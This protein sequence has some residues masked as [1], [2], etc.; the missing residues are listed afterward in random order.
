[1]KFNKNKLSLI[2]INTTLITGVAISP[3]ALAQAPDLGEAEQYSIL[4]GST[5]TNTGGTTVTHDVGV[6]PGTAVTGFADADG[7]PGI[8]DPG[9]L[10]S[11]AGSAQAK[12][13][14]AVAYGHL[15]GLPV[16]TN[17]AAAMGSGMILTPGVYSFTG[18]ADIT[19]SL[20]LDANGDAEALFIFQIPAELNAASNSQVS[21]IDNAQVYNVYWQVGTSATLGTNAEFIGNILADQ[22]ITM[23]TGASLT[24]RALA[25]NA[26]TTLDTNAVATILAPTPP[27]SVPTLPQWSVIFLALALAVV[28]FLTMRKPQGKVTA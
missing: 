20:V 9:S 24:G 18:A 23:N 2:L 28:G 1:M 4:A 13:D 6:H 14:L 17:Q 25:I 12:A 8:I 15:A 22:S 3:L 21:L 19:G 11:S 26:A 27:I 5:V 7:G 10:R 16:D